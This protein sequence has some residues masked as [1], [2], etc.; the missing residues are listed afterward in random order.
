MNIQLL[1]MRQEL[2]FC[3]EHTL[4]V[5]TS[6]TTK[7]FL[8]LILRLLIFISHINFTCKFKK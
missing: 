8:V 3:L 2:V 7:E 5:H 4:L 1:N 6:T